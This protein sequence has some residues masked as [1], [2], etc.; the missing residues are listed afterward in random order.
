MFCWEIEKKKRRASCF[1]QPVRLGGKQLP[2]CHQTHLTT[3]P[4]FAQ[5]FVFRILVAYS[6]AWVCVGS[7]LFA[8]IGEERDFDLAGIPAAKSLKL[9]ALQAEVEILFAG[10]VVR[11]VKTNPVKGR[12]LPSHG[13]DLMLEGTRLKAVLDNESEAFAIIPI[14]Q[15]G[16]ES[17]ER[18]ENTEPYNTTTKSKMNLEDKNKNRKIGSLLKGLFTLLVATGPN[19]YAQDDGDDAIR[20][21]PFEVS[22]DAG[23]SLYSIN[24]S[25]TG[26]RISAVVRELPFSLDVLTMD[27]LDDF[28]YTDPSDALTEFSNVGAG[29]AHSGA[30]GGNTTR[31]FAQWYALRDGFYRNGAIDKTFIDRVEV[32][33]GPYAAI[34]GRGE[35]GGLVNYIPKVPVY[36]ENSGE[37]TLQYGQNNTYRIHLEQNV[38]IGEKTALLLGGS[39]FERDF[40]LE[41]SYERTRNI[42]ALLRHKLTE[43][44]EISLDFEY[45]MRRNNRG[46]GIP[47]MRTNASGTYDGIDLGSG[48]Y[49]GL[50]AKDFVDEYGYI[51]PRG[52]YWWGERKVEAYNMKWMHK[53]TDAVNLRVAYGNQNQDQPYNNA[54][55]AGST[56][57]VDENLDFVRWDSTGDPSYN[58]IN[59][60]GRALNI[61]LTIDWDIG[62]SKHTTLITWDKSFTDKDRFDFRPTLDQAEKDRLAADRYNIYRDYKEYSPA[63]YAPGYDNITRNLLYR[64]SVDGFFMMH[65]ARFFDEKLLVMLGSRY[66][67]SRVTE[68]DLRKDSKTVNAATATTYNVGVNYS[69]TP[70]TM[71][72]ASHAT[73]FNPKGGFYTDA[74]RA[75]LPNESGKGSELGIRTSLIEDRVDVGVSYYEIERFNIRI[76]NPLYDEDAINPA[77]GYK[78]VPEIGDLDSNGDPFSDE[79]ID[80]FRDDYRD[81][82]STVIPGGVDTVN[83]YEVFA[84]GRVN[85]NLSFR[86]AWGTADTEYKV[87]QNAYLVGQAFRKVPSWTYSLSA[88]YKVL[89]GR[90]K[91]MN[92]GLNYKG[93]DDYRTQDRN[94]INDADRRW[95][96]R[97]DNLL[98]LRLSASYGWKTEERSHKVAVSVANAFDRIAVTRDE[99]LTEGRNIQASYTLKY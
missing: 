61:D 68:I 73:S 14:E 41:Y 25:S 75:P 70:R 80:T 94:W 92:F 42:G 82:V 6:I 84:N 40:D 36:G 19:I 16:G 28:H 49:V 64:T 52:K 37:M 17:P 60:G 47:V 77:N 96:L 86:A 65:R 67:D 13:L 32:I 59:E 51:N 62:E 69:V 78:N 55:S 48:K 38:A 58:E 66:D 3:F 98:D 95:Y 10:S 29:E 35:P 71:V 99:Y 79:Q 72:Y 54:S 46:R 83:G 8:A 87:N 57:R 56:I 30:G 39:Y 18:S 22:S 90:L 43:N 50:Y 93:Q 31:G 63:T 20:L 15:K 88:N 76:N 21:S 33:K 5:S 23:N 45:M 27:Y 1:S 12:Y 11:G 85:D 53:F 74:G 81:L 91:G 26:T 2:V 34:Y 89:E 9:A 7:T 24:Q 4:F 44:D 97:S